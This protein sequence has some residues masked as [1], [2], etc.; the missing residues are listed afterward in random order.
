MIDRRR[1]FALGAAVAVACAGAAPALAGGRGSRRTDA[2]NHQAA[3]KNASA[4]L[5]RI[6]LPAG[7]IRSSTEPTGDGGALGGP[8]F[9]EGVEKLVDKHAWWTVSAAPNQVFS[10]IESHPPRGGTENTTCAGGGT[11]RSWSCVGFGFP[12][13]AG[14]LGVRE[15]AVKVVG[16]GNGSTG[17]RADAEV[18]WI[19]VRPASERVPSGVGEIEV[20]RDGPHGGE[21]VAVGDPST[22]HK[23]IRL[24]DALPV[25]QPGS[26]HCPAIPSSAAMD[27]FSFRPPGGGPALARASVRADVGRSD[28]GCDAMSFS[29]GGRR[30]M[31]LVGAR[32][33]LLAVGHLLDFRLTQ[34]P[35]G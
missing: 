7:A 34:K 17:I 3:V 15:L 2:Q 11:Q 30:Q 32:R 27:S 5:S 9:T 25:V 1:S 8:A 10:Y 35:R 13:R 29:I 33:F 20:A 12:E 16:L 18:Q 28:T 26:W 14:V 21:A 22:I 4:L 23:I 19:I 24:F 31:P 6:N